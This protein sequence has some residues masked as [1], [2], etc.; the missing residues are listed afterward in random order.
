MTSLRELC[1]LGACVLAPVVLTATLMVACGGGTSQVQAFK[2]A[3]LVVFGD[4]NSLIENDGTNDGFKYSINDRA[5][6]TTGR[7]L[8]L[9]TFSQMVASI[10]GFVFAECNPN[11]DTPRAIIRAMR[12]AK[13]D[14]PTT[15]LAQQMA[16]Q[17]DLGS[18]DMVTVMIGTN[19]VI[20]VY[21]RTQSGLSATD[22]V[23]E[24]RR[25]GTHAAELVNAILRT[26]ARALVLTIPDIGL[27]PYAYNANTIDPG[28]SAL[29]TRLTY[30]Y[31]AYLRTHIDSSTYD[32]R[33]YG[34][35]LA[36]DIV[37]A[38][39]K[40]PAAFLATPA[41]ANAPACVLAL[42]QT[43]EAVANAVLNCTTGTLVDGATSNSH[44]WASDRHL[45]PAA[46][47]HIGQQAQSRAVNNPF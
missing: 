16:S 47:S 3:R 40:S 13:V 12:H 6:A 15:G 20:E 8:A 7:C 9:P 27:S 19:D 24:A 36:D 1:R 4:E 5:T 44:L 46:H 35:V 18:H 25:R 17:G 31:N 21:E 32:G 39:A 10:Y 11:A 22:A 45:G 23:D 29:L 41:I 42:G 28:A 34:L 43:A 2:P 30:E 33:N 37:A 14:D 38:M 26:G